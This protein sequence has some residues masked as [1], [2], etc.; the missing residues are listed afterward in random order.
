[1]ER[2]KNKKRLIKIAALAVC[3]VLLIVFAVFFAV[4]YTINVQ[5]QKRE[6]NLEN[7]C[8]TVDT[9]RQISER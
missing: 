9:M 1:M 6:T 3:N 2:I 4:R 8:N 5:M 7:F